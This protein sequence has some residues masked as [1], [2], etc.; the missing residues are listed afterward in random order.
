MPDRSLVCFELVRAHRL[1]YWSYALVLG[2]SCISI[3]FFALILVC[4]DLTILTTLEELF[5]LI[6][7]DKK[8][9]LTIPKIQK[10]FEED[11]NGFRIK[12]IMDRKGVLTL[13]DLV[14]VLDA[15]TTR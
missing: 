14:K 1:V 13:E 3:G 4:I 7:Y 5:H 12:E 11:A 10:F 9:F 2:H 15:T 8:G 6:D